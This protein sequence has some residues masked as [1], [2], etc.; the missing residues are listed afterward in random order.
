MRINDISKWIELL[1]KPLTG[2]LGMP[3]RQLYISIGHATVTG[4][5]LL[6]ICGIGATWLWAEYQTDLKSESYAAGA[7]AK[8]AE[9]RGYE[10]ANIEK[11]GRVAGSS[12]FRLLA[13]STDATGAKIRLAKMTG[14]SSVIIQWSASQPRPVSADGTTILRSP[15]AVQGLEVY[16]VTGEGQIF[17]LLLSPSTFGNAWVTGNRISFQ[18]EQIDGEGAR[19][20]AT[21]RSFLLVP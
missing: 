10:L 9:A 19:Q 6:G 11:E 16:P 3:I 1:I 7:R 5:L 20:R 21:A 2:S 18:I 15:P 8:E 17:E 12:T 13:I 14:A 4:Y